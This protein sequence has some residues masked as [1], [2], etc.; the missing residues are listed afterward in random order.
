MSLDETL[1]R[2]RQFEQALA[3]FD[4]AQRVALAALERRHG[5]VQ[6]VWQDQFSRDYTHL[7]EPLGDGLRRW[8]QREGPAY[9]E[10]I[11]DKLHSLSLY[12]GHGR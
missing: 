9:R 5:D 7:W 2:M 1:E 6:A 12:L 4:E 3:R 8:T 11:A 10:F